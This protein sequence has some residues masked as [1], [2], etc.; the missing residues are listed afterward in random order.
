[1]RSNDDNKRRE[2]ELGLVCMTSSEACRFRTIT[3]TRYLQLQPRERHAALTEL[4]ADNLARLH[5]ALDFCVAN[6]IRLYRAPSSLFP[7]SDERIGEE[8]LR[9]MAAILR[10]VGR[11]AKKQALRVVLHPDQFVVLNSDSDSVIATS[12][13]ILE[14]H[15]LAFD[16]MG[17]PK[18]SWTAFN[19]H[20]GKRSQSERL[21]DVIKNRLPRNVHNRLTIENDEYSYGAAEVLDIC[22]RTGVPMVFDCHHHVIREKLDSYDHP[23]IARY[24]HLS[25]GTWPDPAWQ[26]VH[27]SNGRASFLDRSHSDLIT[28][29]PKANSEA[30]WIEVEAKGKELAIERLRASR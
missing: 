30:P 16:L 10:S 21:I 17:L 7:M 1:M 11:R 25:A 13:N 20:G 5:L 12:I 28:H 2:P 27:L 4:Y 24:T 8:V 14:K 9:S 26:L 23:S 6:S 18:T 22:R 3:R 29:V 15:A 19:I